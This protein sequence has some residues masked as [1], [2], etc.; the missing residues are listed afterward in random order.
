MAE[1]GAKILL[2][3]DEEETLMLLSFYLQ[4]AGFQVILAENGR[5]A[6]DKARQEKPDI[7]ILDRMMP[8][9]DGIEVCR[10][11][12]QSD[13][14]IFVVMLTA[15][16]TDVDRITG[17]EAGADDYLV[18]PFNPKELVLKV[19]AI[20][21]RIKPEAVQT[22]AQTQPPLPTAKTAPKA[23]PVPPQAV[24]VR[25]VIRPAQVPTQNQLPATSQTIRA[26]SPASTSPLEGRAGNLPPVDRSRATQPFPDNGVESTIARNLQATLQEASRAAQAQDVTRARQLY[27]QVLKNDPS[28]ESALMW[29]AWYTTDPY[30]GCGYLER[31]VAAHPDNMKAREFLEAGRRR[32]QELDQLISDSSVLSYWNVAEQVQQDRLRK[33]VDRRN[34]PVLPV[35][36]LLLRKGFITREQLDT[37]VSLHEMFNRLGDPKKLGEVLLEYGYLTREQLQS[38]LNEQQAEYNS[39]FY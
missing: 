1:T 9:M 7:L 18:K 31:L 15:M 30:E 12:H 24:P 23:P 28:N 35:G 34:N 3:D 16:G 36:Q 10:Q 11:L 20:I 6:L 8:E 4:R 14:A 21:R 29:L 39:Q 32:L 38:V 17:M 13:P 33:G 27:Q 25:P 19:Q 26:S 22:V 37:A 2:A 5:E